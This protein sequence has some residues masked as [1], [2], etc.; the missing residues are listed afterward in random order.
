MP[1]ALGVNGG[2]LG[3]NNLPSSGSAKGIW[4][5]N[6]IARAVALGFWPVNYARSITETATGADVISTGANADPYFN[7]TTLLLSTTATNGQQNNT[8]QDSST[9]NFTITRNP[10]TGPNAPT[11]GTFSPFSQTG[12][13]GAFNTST[14][15]LTVTDTANLR[16]GLSNFTIEAWVYRNASG[17]TQTIASKG[18]S[19]PT[20][21]VFQIS[22]ADKLVFT[23][24]STS[25]T[26]TTSIAANTW[27]YVAVVRAGTGT[28]QTTLYVNGTSDGTGTSAT[29]FN[30]TSNMLVGADRSTTNFANGY[31]SNLRLSNTNRTISSTPTTSLTA[32]SNTIFLSLNLNRFQY[33]DSTAAYT[34]ISITGTPS[35]VAFS[36]FNPS[37]SWSA[38]TYGG[39]G[40]FDGSGDYL[41][42]TVTVS[43]FYTDLGDFTFEGW[44]YPLSFLGPQYSCPLFAFS[45]D[46][47]M[48]RAMPTSATS[49]SLNI[50]GLTSAG[51]PAFGSTGISGGTI[52]LNEWAWVVFTR[53]SGVLNIWV[54]G[55]RV[56][57]DS[58]YTATQ[59]R[60]TATSLRIG[61]GFSGSPAPLWNG[62][63]SGIKWTSGAALYSGATISMPTAP[64]TTTVSSGTNR[65]LLNFT[66]PGIYDATA[67]NVLETVGNAQVSTAQSK[68]SPTSMSFDGTGDYLLIPDNPSQRIGTGNFTVE[69]WVYRNASGTYGLI[70]KGTGTTGWLLSLN[71]SNQVVF[72]YGSSTITSTGTISATTWT[73][74]AVVRSG[75][76]T[77]LTKIYIS[78]TND[79]TGTVSTDFN[80]TNAMYVAADRTGGS[81]ANAY[82]QDTRVTLYARYSANF[83][84]PTAAFPVQ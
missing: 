72:T 62:Y 54:N 58:A 60:Q 26:G 10:A 41:S 31:I 56:V 70:G 75:T 49:T 73:H 30:Q 45:S 65:L 42:T 14:T 3:S 6:E 16:F 40:Y 33:T 4:T 19:T 44:V 83:T 39:S 66:N 51:G 28:N 52:R 36:P 25:I 7:L 81:N 21:W 34:N 38:A 43:N 69:C 17:A 68:W 47:L 15:Y 55:T 59:L 13:G 9:N 18:A 77:N 24:T 50:Y 74:I 1:V 57:N 46:D 78:G 48:L 80:Q 32:D 37:A 35:V 23:D 8:F 27:T 20:G 63:L 76:G 29:N 53:Q 61:G 5:T 79:G 64:P 22:S 71:S 11:Q 12:W 82:V 67:K 2:V 84:P